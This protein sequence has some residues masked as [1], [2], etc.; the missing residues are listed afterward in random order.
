M[1]LDQSVESHISLELDQEQGDDDISDTKTIKCGGGEAEDEAVLSVSPKTGCSTETETL[2]V[3]SK[4]P[5]RGRPRVN[6]ERVV[7][8]KDKTLTRAQLKAA[9][10][11]FP[12]EDDDTAIPEGYSQVYGAMPR[13]SLEDFQIVDAKP[14]AKR[15]RPAGGLSPEQWVQRLH[16]M[17]LWLVKGELPLE[18][19]ADRHKKKYF[20]NKLAKTFRMI[21]GQLYTYHR[22]PKEVRG[23]YTA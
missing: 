1:A 19:E 6:D 2:S 11:A 9:L 23:N 5:K 15:G 16:D 7:I 4:T 17:R 8:F 3:A 12:E 20:I 14:K 18:C 21:D 22:R 10:E 13:N